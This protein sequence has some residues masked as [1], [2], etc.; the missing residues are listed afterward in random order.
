MAL[1]FPKVLEGCHIVFWVTSLHLLNLGRTKFPG[2]LSQ[3]F[4][5]FSSPCYSF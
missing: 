4:P 1:D 5:A 2:Q 3:L